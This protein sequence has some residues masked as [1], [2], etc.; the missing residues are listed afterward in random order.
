MINRRRTIL[1]VLLAL[2]LIIGAVS[3]GSYVY[4][5]GVAQGA[6]QSVRLSDLPPGAAVAPYAY[7][8]G[9]FYRPFGFFGPLLFFFLIFLLFRGLWWGGR[10]GRGPGWRPN[11]W[12]GGVP[13]AFEEW[14]RRAHRGEQTSNE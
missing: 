9:P 3:L 1:G 2:V 12:E 14:H 8:G 13:P 6:A 4:N 5:L 11:H 7:Y 10:W